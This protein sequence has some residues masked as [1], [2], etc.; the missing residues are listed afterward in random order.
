MNGPGRDGERACS[1]S[2]GWRLAWSV[3]LSIAADRRLVLLPEIPQAIPARQALAHAPVGFDDLEGLGS[4]GVDGAG[5]DRDDAAS[6]AR[7]EIAGR[8]PDSLD[9]NGLADTGDEAVGCDRGDRHSAGE[10]RKIGIDILDV[11]D[12][13]SKPA[14]IKR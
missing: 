6:A 10:E 12:G 5:R 7:Y 14:R 11:A 8:D 13:G 3:G 1:V 9:V 2:L 4:N